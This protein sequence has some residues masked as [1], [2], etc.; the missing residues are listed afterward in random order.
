MKR[1][2]GTFI[3]FMI[4]FLSGQVFSQPA[5]VNCDECSQG[6]D[7]KEQFINCMKQSDCSSIKL[8]KSFTITEALNVSGITRIVSGKNPGVKLIIDSF[9]V[10]FEKIIFNL[11]VESEGV[12]TS[13]IDCEFKEN[14]SLS[15]VNVTSNTLNGSYDFQNSEGAIFNIEESILTAG[16]G[17]LES[18]RTTISNSLFRLTNGKALFFKGDNRLV[19]RNLYRVLTFNNNYETIA[20]PLALPSIINLNKIVNDREIGLKIPEIEY[21]KYANGKFQIEIKNNFDDKHWENIECESVVFEP[22][23]VYQPNGIQGVYSL[24]EMYTYQQG[25][26]KIID[27]KDDKIVKVKGN[28]WV[29]IS[30]KNIAIL[31]H[32]YGYGTSAFSNSTR[33]YKS[34]FCADN[35]VWSESYFKCI[36]KGLVSNN[37]NCP[38]GTHSEADINLCMSNFGSQ[39]TAWY[40]INDTLPCGDKC[41]LGPDQDDPQCSGD[42]DCVEN[43]ICS[44]GSCIDNPRVEPECTENSDCA[45]NQVCAEGV[46]ADKPDEVVLEC[47]TN[48]QCVDGQE[49]KE[50]KCVESIP[51]PI[52]EP[53]PVV[54][55]DSG[56]SAS[57]CSLIR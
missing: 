30:N 27:I 3:I 43:Q 23:L 55:V 22:Y 7:S 5:A 6:V 4:I 31:A 48:E 42:S 21:K 49:C 26:P 56:T 13:F 14:S 2:C 28:I 11:P 45:E 32:C 20:G 54:P 19:N 34:L 10:R 16:I 15:A 18:F 39:S 52:P 8:N 50:N 46:C 35:Q 36:P 17:V 33:I 1:V 25:K 41:C 51:G 12:N 47:L 57:G 38:D 9:G 53:A 44:D 29:Q 37:E 40:C 24:G